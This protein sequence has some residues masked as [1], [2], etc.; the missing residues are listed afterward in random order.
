MQ[1]SRSTRTRRLP[2][3]GAVL[4]VGLLIAAEEGFIVV[5][6]TGI[7]AS[8]DE[9]ARNSWEVADIDDPAK[10]DLAFLDALLD[11]VLTDYFADDT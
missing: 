5:H 11:L 3:V 6:P 4:A 9:E 10:D 2:V 1:L 7:P 8:G